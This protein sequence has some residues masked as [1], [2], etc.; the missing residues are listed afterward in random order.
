MMP[1]VPVIC[2]FELHD[3]VDQTVV[4]QPVQVMPGSTSLALYAS[5]VSRYENSFA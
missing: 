5:V 1:Y 3:S 4:G 2:A